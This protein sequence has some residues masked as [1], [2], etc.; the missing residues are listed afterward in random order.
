MANEIKRENDT[1][2]NMAQHTLTGHTDFGSALESVFLFFFFGDDTHTHSNGYLSMTW[3][4]ND[5]VHKPEREAGIGGRSGK[6]KMFLELGRCGVQNLII[7]R[8]GEK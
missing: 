4:T 6:K 2:E 8:V 1:T 5:N 3:P 7:A